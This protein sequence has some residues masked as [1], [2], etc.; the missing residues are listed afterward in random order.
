MLNQNRNAVC[1]QHKDEVLVQLRQLA[2]VEPNSNYEN[3]DATRALRGFESL[4]PEQ[5]V[6]PGRMFIGSQND[7]EAEPITVPTYEVNL[8]SP[9]YLQ[10]HYLSLLDLLLFHGNIVS[11]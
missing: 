4:V 2:K 5:S 6:Q 10:S 11:L 3:V 1:G 9:W 8:L 7:A